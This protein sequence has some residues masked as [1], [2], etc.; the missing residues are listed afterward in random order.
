[1]LLMVIVVSFNIY[2][3]VIWSFFL[4]LVSLV[5]HLVFCLLS[6]CFVLLPHSSQ[7]FLCNSLL[8]CSTPFHVT[9]DVR[10]NKVFFQTFN[11]F[12]HANFGQAFGDGSEAPKHR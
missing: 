4:V 1:M 11:K 6:S 9:I 2:I 12:D 3:K 8:L 10:D 5:M 7:N